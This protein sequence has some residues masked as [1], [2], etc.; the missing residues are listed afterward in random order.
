M[1]LAKITGITPAVFTLMGIWVDWPPY[2]FRPTMRL[3]YWTR[4]RR[5]AC[6]M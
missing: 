3:A 6:C 2:T 4:M 5:C 1:E